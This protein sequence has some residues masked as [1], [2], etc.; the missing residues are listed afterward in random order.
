MTERLDR[1]LGFLVAA[2]GLKTLTGEAALM[3]GTRRENL[4][5]RAW[6][7]ALWALLCGRSEDGDRDRLIA[8]CLVAD[9]APETLALLPQ[10]QADG[11][12]ALRREAH[13]GASAE[14]HAW[15]R[16]ALAQALMQEIGAGPLARSDREALVTA[17]DIG[18]A[19]TLADDWPEL[20]AHLTGLLSG[21][22]RP[23]PEPLGAR[24]RF[25]AEADR[26]KS[27]LRGTTI[28]DGARRENSAEHSWHLALFALTLGEHATTA[29]DMARAAR[30]LILHDLVEI[31]A[32]DMPIH[33][34]HDPAAQEAAE[35]RAADRLYGLLPAREGA[36]LRALWEEF[37]AAGSPD[38]IYA[39]SI[40]RVQ[41]VL[42]NLATGGGTWIDYAVTRAQL[43]SRV[44]DRVRRGAPSLWAALVPRLD[45][46]FGPA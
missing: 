16:L 11:L 40:D 31:D 43:E 10:D 39:K 9:L 32:G 6:H 20:H 18:P 21:R 2:D 8:L 36:A 22:A 42:A 7:R 37:E 23:A 45:A 35:A 24:L 19:A 3:D 26:L 41:P 44:G 28:F 5:E 29:P 25:L 17:L 38:A 12:D 27:V 1:H 15:R 46:W 14:A 33:G 4:A 13:E 34:S 30:M